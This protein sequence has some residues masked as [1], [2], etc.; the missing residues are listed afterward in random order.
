MLNLD[1]KKR[2]SVYKI[3]RMGFIK[4]Q[5]KLA[6]WRQPKRTKTPSKYRKK[7]NRFFL[8]KD[9]IKSA[10]VSIKQIANH[11][12]HTHMHSFRI[13]QDTDS[14][15]QPTKPRYASKTPAARPRK[16]AT[17]QNT[18]KDAY[19]KNRRE[20]ISKLKLEARKMQQN[21]ESHRMKPPTPGRLRYFTKMSAKKSPS[22]SRNNS[23]QFKK[24]FYHQKKRIQD[25]GF[26]SKSSKVHRSR[27]PESVSNYMDFY[28][29]K[30]SKKSESKKQFFFF[31]KKMNDDIF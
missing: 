16:E 29:N 24:H 19:I 28:R 20:K 3:L 8:Q 21:Q 6:D 11:Q 31:Q 13:D 14:H 15:R 22:R 2:P 1:P 18:R 12:L 27:T 9:K 4:E 23:E 5:K 26:Q 25:F 30:F 17:S 7:L 10:K